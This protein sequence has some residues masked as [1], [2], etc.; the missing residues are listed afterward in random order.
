MNSQRVKVFETVQF[1][2]F[3]KI[4]YINK[5]WLTPQEILRYLNNAGN[6]KNLKPFISQMDCETRDDVFTCDNGRC[7]SELWVCDGYDDCEDFSDERD[8]DTP[9]NGKKWSFF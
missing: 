1:S 3:W 7:V 6:N 2:S 8:C 4:N 9:G 5:S